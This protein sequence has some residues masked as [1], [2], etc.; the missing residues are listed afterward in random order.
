MRLG[1]ITGTTLIVP[2]L[3][4]A[5]VAYVE[6]LSLTLSEQSPLRRQ[7]ALDMGE[8]VLI[9]A[10]TAT[11]TLGGNVA[12][13]LTLIEAPAVL[14]PAGTRGWTQLIFGVSHLDAVCARLRAEH[15]TLL[16]MQ[17]CNGESKTASADFRG[18]AG[19]L[20]CLRESNC[21]QVSASSSGVVHSLLGVKLCV[22]DLAAA[23]GFYQGLGLVRSGNPA[24]PEHGR[25]PEGE[26]SMQRLGELRG[27]QHIAFCTAPAGAALAGSLRLGIRMVSLARSDQHGRQL[28]AT[29]DPSARIL[30]G[31]EHEAIEF[32]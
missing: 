21:D 13:S 3:K 2:D 19:E 23:V 7:R 24:R 29:D 1:P 22:A 26:S 25:M 14:A 31:P 4:R 27:G 17:H 10:P 15:W 11:L 30:A 16:N 8:T 28:L 5:L 12:S 20:I 32:I 9:D 6:Q 18:P